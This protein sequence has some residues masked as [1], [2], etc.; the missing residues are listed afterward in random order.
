MPTPGRKF[1]NKLFGRNSANWGK[2]NTTGGC[3]KRRPW[4]GRFAG[5]LQ[6]DSHVEGDIQAKN[7]VVHKGA[8]V[9]GAITAR[10]IHINGTVNGEIVSETVSLGPDAIVKGNIRY[11]T[12]NIATGASLWGL[13]LDSRRRD[14]AGQA[15]THFNEGPP[16]PF[17]RAWATCRKG[18][19]VQEIC[20]KPKI[21]P[22]IRSMKA[23]WESYQKG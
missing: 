2:A 9:D 6:I 21:Q 23:V 1:P 19:I 4:D 17:S 5:A 20:P 16:L 14:F 3:E 15:I 12:L 13:C 22:V 7:I 8:I 10:T 18:R 11:Q